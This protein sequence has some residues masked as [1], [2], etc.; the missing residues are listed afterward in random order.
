M[1]TSDAIHAFAAEAAESG[2][3]RMHNICLRA[4]DLLEGGEPDSE[5]AYVFANWTVAEAMSE[6]QDSL[7]EASDA[8]CEPDYEPSDYGPS[9]A[10]LDLEFGG[11]VYPDSRY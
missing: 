3:L 10:A 7:E 2:D 6:V 1:K 9:K 5:E 4:M 8:D 11:V